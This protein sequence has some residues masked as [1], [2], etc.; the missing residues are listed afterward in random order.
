[1]QLQWTFPAALSVLLATSSA[2]S[3]VECTDYMIA[4][5]ADKTSFNPANCHGRPRASQAQIAAGFGKDTGFNSKTATC[6]TPHT[7]N[8]VGV[9]QAKYKPGQTV[10]LAYPAKNHASSPGNKFIPDSGVV[11]SRT[12]VGDKTDTFDGHTYKHNNGDHVKGVVDGKGFQNCPA[13]G[14][15]ETDKALCTLCFALEPDLAPG[16]YAFKWTWNFNSPTD[17]YSTC[18]DAN[19]DVSGGLPPT[20][21]PPANPSGSPPPSTLSSPSMSPSSQSEGLSGTPSS[22]NCQQQVNDVDFHGN[23]LVT[24]Y[25]LQP[26]DCC[27]KCSLTPGCKAYTFV[28]SQ[29]ACYLKST[30]GNNQVTKV[31]TVS[32]LLS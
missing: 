30:D 23:D 32:A 5:D 16:A 19:V 13:F 22:A 29:L 20:V 2:H 31:G 11:I 4:T 17:S 3:W 12:K 28:M 21:A 14:S 7:D 1:M 18:W 10:C 6:P 26:G 8:D 15:P 24:V 9:P 25:G 27:A